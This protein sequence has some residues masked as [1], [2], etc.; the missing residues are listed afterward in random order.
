MGFSKLFGGGQTTVVAPA[1]DTTPPPTVTETQDTNLQA[2]YAQRA[3]RRR[4]LLSTILSNRNRSNALGGG[5][6]GGNTTLG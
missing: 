4:G 2:D 1:T 5:D 6:S 3:S